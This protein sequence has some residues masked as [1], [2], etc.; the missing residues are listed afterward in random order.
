MTWW[1]FIPI[2]LQPAVEL[3]GGEMKKDQFQM[4]LRNNTT[5]KQRYTMLIN[6]R[7][8]TAQNVTVHSKE[9]QL[10]LSAKHLMP[11]KNEI[12]LTNQDDTVHIECTN[13]SIPINTTDFESIDLQTAFNRS[14]T[15]IFENQYVSPR[16]QTATLQLPTTGIGNWCYP[17]IARDVTIDDSGLRQTASQNNGT[18]TFANIPFQTVSNANENNIAFVSQWDTFDD[19]LTIN[20]SGK[21]SQAYFMMAGSTNHMQTQMTNGSITVHYLDGSTDSLLLNNPENWWPIEQDYYV[22]DFAFHIDSPRPPRV[23]FKTGEITTEQPD[24]VNLKGFSAFGIDGGAGQILNLPL[25]PEK[26]LDYLSLKAVTNEVV[27]GLM[28]VTLKRP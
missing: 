26:E 6:H 23:Y 28:S 15:S 25:H 14:V 7:N 19:S 21:A 16:S 20:L 22:D 13:W 2:H 10:N 18:I 1:Q 5:E 17:W 8:E 3:I 11:G 12:R 24:Y 9:A 27:I 4:K